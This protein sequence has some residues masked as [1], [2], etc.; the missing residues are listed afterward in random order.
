MFIFIYAIN[1]EDTFLYIM[2][3]LLFLVCNFESNSIMK[4]DPFFYQRRWMFSDVIKL[5]RIDPDIHKELLDLAEYR[6][7][8]SNVV[9]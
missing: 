1:S 4:H 7:S 2:N 9:Q 3:Y 5:M 8:L 6:D